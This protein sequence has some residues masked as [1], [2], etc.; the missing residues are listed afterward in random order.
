MAKMEKMF[1]DGVDSTGGK[2][3]LWL[4]LLSAQGG[5]HPWGCAGFRFDKQFFIFK[6]S[7]LCHYVNLVSISEATLYLEKQYT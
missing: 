2:A 1:E 4:F 3:A 7:K 6:L 5:S